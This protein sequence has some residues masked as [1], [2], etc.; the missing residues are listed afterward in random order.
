MASGNVPITYSSGDAIYIIKNGVNG[1]LCNS[2]EEI[3]EKINYLTE[4]KNRLQEMGENAYNTIHE[5]FDWSNSVKEMDDILRK[6]EE[7]KQK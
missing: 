7:N 5:Q 6:F 1:F 2:M 4:N 3:I